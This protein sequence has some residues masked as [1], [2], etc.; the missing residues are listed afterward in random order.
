MTE[1]VAGDT[2]MRAAL[3]TGVGLALVVTAE[4]FRAVRAFGDAGARLRTADGEPRA[5]DG[6]KVEAGVGLAEVDVQPGARTL[7]ST[8]IR[9]MGSSRN[10][11]E[12]SRA[13]GVS[14]SRSPHAGRIGASREKTLLVTI[15]PLRYSTV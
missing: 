2:P 1:L 4:G 11:T 13:S 8:S 15:Q 10:R 12:H 14:G 6:R 7:Q 5:A 3:D 9:M